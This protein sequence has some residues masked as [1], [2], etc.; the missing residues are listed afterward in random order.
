MK[1]VFNEGNKGDPDMYG[2]QHQ[3]SPGPLDWPTY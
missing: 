2:R 1:K 3:G